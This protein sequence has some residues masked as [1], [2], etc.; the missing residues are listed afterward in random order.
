MI[1]LSPE[2]QEEVALYIGGGEPII[3]PDYMQL[4]MTW[5]TLNRVYNEN[6]SER[7]ETQQVISFGDQ[8][9]EIW[10]VVAPLAKKLVSLECIGGEKDPNGIYRPKREVKSATIF[11]REYFHLV[12]FV[13]VNHCEFIACRLEIRNACDSVA[14]ES[15]NHSRMGALLRVVYQVRCNLVHGDKRLLARGYQGD[16]DRELVRLSYDILKRILR[17][18]GS[19]SGIAV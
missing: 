6:R 5:S 11:L 12:D 1:H 9:D 13:D 8:I 7:S 17:E 10:Y 14:A 3:P 15:W 16:R 4:A 19:S 2:T 18:I